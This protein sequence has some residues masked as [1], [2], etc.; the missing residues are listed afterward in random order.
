MTRGFGHNGE[1]RVSATDIIFATV[2]ACGR[3]VFRATYAGM[4]S[5]EDVIGALRRAAEKVMQGPVTVSLRNSSQGWTLQRPMLRRAA[6]P[7]ATQLTL[8]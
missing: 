3:T 1:K 6:T 7:E 4:S 5:I 2:M 8:F